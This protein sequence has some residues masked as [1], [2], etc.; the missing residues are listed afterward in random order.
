MSGTH[1]LISAPNRARTGGSL[2]DTMPTFPAGSDR[3]PTSIAARSSARRC[4]S[5]VAPSSVAATDAFVWRGCLMSQAAVTPTAP[6]TMNTS[7]VNTPGDCSRSL[8]NCATIRL[9]RPGPIASA[10]ISSA[11]QVIAAMICDCDSPAVTSSCP[12]SAAATASDTNLTARHIP[13][14]SGSGGS[15]RRR[16]LSSAGCLSCARPALA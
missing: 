11:Q 13:C 2:I 16:P 14:G 3:R 15:T 9:R 4:L 8:K 12:S 10:G 5:S 6:Q 1:R 7:N